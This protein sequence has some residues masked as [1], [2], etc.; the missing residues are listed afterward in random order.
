MFLST[1]RT[2]CKEKS[3]NILNKVSLYTLIRSKE[4]LTLISE[5]HPKL[6]S[7]N[8]EEITDRGEVFNTMSTELSKSTHFS[9]FSNIKQTQTKQTFP[10]LEE[11]IGKPQTS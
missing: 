6:K 9:S 1:K 4:A 7:E 11:K 2:K 5:Q 3:L 8:R 10:L